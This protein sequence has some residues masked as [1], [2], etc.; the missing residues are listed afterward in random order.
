MSFVCPMDAIVIDNV[1][2]QFRKTVRRHHTTLKTEIIRWFRK[3]RRPLPH[4]FIQSLDGVSLRVPQGQTMG[5]IG[6]N[7]AGK[8]TLLKIITGIYSPTSGTVEVN[9]R[10]SALLDLGAGFHPDFS[11]R[12][13]I[14]ING[15]ILGMSRSEI[16]ARMPAIIDF[17]ELGDFVDEPVRTYSSGMYMRLAFSVAT[18][19]DPD[20]LLIDE[21]LAVGDEHFA[22]KSRAKMNEFKKGGKTIVLVTHDLNT[23]QTWCDRAAW[24]D[25][26]RIRAVG[27]PSEVV[28]QYR[29]AVALADGETT[30]E[31]IADQQ[32]SSALPANASGRAVNAGGAER[33]AQLVI[34]GLRLTNQF[35]QEISVVGPNDSLDVSFDFSTIRTI[36]KA[37]FAITIGRSDGQTIYSTDTE[38]DGILLPRPLPSRGTICLKLEQL[39]LGDGNYTVELT[40]EVEGIARIERRASTFVVRSGLPD[41]GLMRL[42]HRWIV[43]ARGQDAFVSRRSAAGS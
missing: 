14:L 28:T 27:I 41:T 11:G 40:A 38:A 3:G 12:E 33:Q 15:I 43:D 35:D 9:G 10:I 39:N 26:G 25:A 2:K 19:V 23:V 8:S 18:H 21:I 20:I 7:G 42:P 36:D 32:I 6:R 24:I 17:S 1:S 37:I 13:N 31:A 29:D 22:H 34:E 16:R 30:A 5:I 4:T